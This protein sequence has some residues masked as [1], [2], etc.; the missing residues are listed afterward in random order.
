MIEKRFVHAVHARDTNALRALLPHRDELRALIDAPRFGFDAPAI[1]AASGSGDV[2]LVDVLL[3]LGADPNARSTWWAGGFHAL[4]GARGAVADRLLEAGAIPD[5]CAAAHLDRPELLAEMLRADPAR[6]HE[7]GGDGQT[8]LHFARSRAVV[9]L[10]LAGGADIEARDVDHRSTAAEWMIGDS[11]RVELARYLVERGATCDIFLAVVLGDVARARALVE[12]EP[13]LLTLRTGHGQYGEM[14][15]SSHHIYYWTI[16]PNMTPLQAAARRGQADMMDVLLPIASP[17]Q[18][19]MAACETGD[20]T[21]ARAIVRENPGIVE[22]LGQQDRGALTDAAWNGNARAV[23]L[24]LELGFDPAIAWGTN[25]SG[26]TALHCAAWQGS[27]A[28]VQALLKHPSGRA[29]LTV[30]DATHG[31]T[32]LD[33]CRHGAQQCGNRDA[34]YAAVEQML[35]A[36]ASD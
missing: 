17:Q 25:T 24:M 34:D 20:R 29:L 12:H 23:E 36:A 2:A 35:V 8:P 9:D 14:P 27:V 22:S 5:A 15:P 11:E 19:L 21:A 13:R 7:R 31:G 16:G 10:L 32:P 1:V 33:W 4:Y 18:R 28:C 6:V 3:Q 26:G 30:R